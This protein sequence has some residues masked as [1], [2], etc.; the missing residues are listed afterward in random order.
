M[1][2]VYISPLPNRSFFENFKR[3]EMTRMK[4]NASFNVQLI[5]L[6]KSV[7]LFFVKLFID[8]LLERNYNDLRKKESPYIKFRS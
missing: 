8:F 3:P 6:Y 4:I 1:V 7:S 5:Q 2:S